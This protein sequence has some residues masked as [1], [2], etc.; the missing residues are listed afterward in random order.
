[1]VLVCRAHR[2]C[3]HRHWAGTE[4]CP[5]SPE[6][7]GNAWQGQLSLLRARERRTGAS[8]GHS[9]SHWRS[10]LALS[11]SLCCRSDPGACALVPG[12]KGDR[13]E[14]GGWEKGER[15]AVPS[16]G[17]NWCTMLQLTM[18]APLASL[19][20]ILLIVLFLVRTLDQEQYI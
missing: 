9:G 3:A 17:L 14:K 4:H 6:R 5:V 20:F 2:H 1:M 13:E 12:P 19:Y 7:G 11:L 18:G 8:A 16:N 15:G 10:S